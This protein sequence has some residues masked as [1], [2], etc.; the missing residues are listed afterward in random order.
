[1][2][3]AYIISVVVV[4]ILLWLAFKEAD[5]EYMRCI[6]GSHPRH[7]QESEDVEFHR[8]FC[9][10]CGLVSHPAR[11]EGDARELWH[12]LVQYHKRFVNNK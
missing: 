7:D 5:R 1:M 6:C 11:V 9:D 12:N 10:K 4:L 8:F 2:I 3:T